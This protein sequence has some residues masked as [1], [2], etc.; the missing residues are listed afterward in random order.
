MTVAGFIGLGNMGRPMAMRIA[1]AGLPLRLWAR[2]PETLEDLLGGKVQAC[3]SPRALGAAADVIGLCVRTDA[4][5][6]DVV[7]REPDGLLGGMRPGSVLLIHAT[8]SPGTIDVLSAAAAAR[9]VALLDAPVSGGAKAAEAGTLTVVLGGDAGIVAKA[10]S[11]LDTYA[12]HTPHVGGLGAAQIVKL[13]N[14]NLCYA[15]VAMGLQAIALAEQLGLD[16]KMAASVIAT[17]SGA[18]HGFGLLMDRALV[19][20][21]A[22]PTSNVRKDVDHFLELINARGIFGSPLTDI[23]TSAAGAV[24]GYAAAGAPA[25][26]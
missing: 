2:R 14:N 15:N 17:S 19:Q 8:V 22:G 9:G 5:V 21:M 26:P 11:V 13:L 12:T 6:L 20:K 1:R 24:A 16:A 7:L 10:R 3:A 18:S 25:T 4:E 23:S